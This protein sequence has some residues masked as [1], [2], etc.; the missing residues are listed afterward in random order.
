MFINATVNRLRLHSATENKTKALIFA[1]SKLFYLYLST[2]NIIKHMI[3]LIKF[4]YNI[5]CFNK[6]L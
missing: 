5:F 3:A 2:C 4:D 1:F 6:N